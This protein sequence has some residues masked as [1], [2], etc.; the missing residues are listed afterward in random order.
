MNS[1]YLVVHK[2]LLPQYLEK[3]IEARALLNSHEVETITEAVRKVGISRN[4]YYKYKDFIYEDKQI[5]RQHAV[6]TL[7]LKDSPGTLS[8]VINTITKNKCN[9]ITISQAVPVSGLAT[10]MIT[11][12]ISKF[13]GHIVQ[14]I[15]E[16]ENLSATK[17]VHLDAVEEQYIPL[18]NVVL[19]LN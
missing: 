11:I 5:A 10:V 17:A 1:D 14:L 9:I 8:S 6:M 19:F 13:K 2:S 7:V 4:T 15:K 18:I 16:L 12:D 3:V